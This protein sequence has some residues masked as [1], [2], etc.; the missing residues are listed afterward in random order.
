M[1]S[2]HLR[3]Q[4]SGNPGTLIGKITSPPLLAYPDYNAL[5][6]VHTD[7]SQDGLGAVLYQKQ[8]G[9]T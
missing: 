8:N 1:D 6:I 5:F 3:D 4:W 7:A 9:S 2:Y